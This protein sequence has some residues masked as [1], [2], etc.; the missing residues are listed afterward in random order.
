MI[1]LVIFI[2]NLSL[3]TSQITQARETSRKVNLELESLDWRK[4]TKGVFKASD[5][6]LSE[7]LILAQ[8]ERWRRA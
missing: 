6:I 8:D 3:K 7:S 2:K 4:E 1:N 5:D